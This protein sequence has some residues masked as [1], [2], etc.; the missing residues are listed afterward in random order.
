MS[1]MASQKG[2][3][4]VWFDP[5]VVVIGGTFSL[6]NRVIWMYNIYTDQWKK[7]EM[8]VEKDQP[9]PPVTMDACAI[10]IGQVIYMFG[11]YH[12]P[13]IIFT[14]RLW[15]LSKTEPEG[16]FAWCE[17]EFQNEVLFPSPR[18]KHCGWEYKEKLWVFGGVGP[19]PA[20]YLDNYFNFKMCERQIGYNNQLL[21]FDPSSKKW[22]DIKCSGTE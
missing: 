6:S 2:H 3:M 4:V 5:S 22:T 1:N 12:Q 21:C 17:V 11:G 15:T 18:A 7:H 13:N 20:G 16:E 14:S 9:I 8:P 10:V 19:S